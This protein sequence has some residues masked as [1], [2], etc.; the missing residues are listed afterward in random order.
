MITLMWS[1]VVLIYSIGGLLW[2]LS[3][4]YLSVR[5]GRQE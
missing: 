3:A 1:F 2:S 4:G 5:F